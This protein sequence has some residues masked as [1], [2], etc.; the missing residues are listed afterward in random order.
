MNSGDPPLNGLPQARDWISQFTTHYPVQHSLGPA[1]A[2]LLRSTLKRI[3]AR[4]PPQ[5]RVHWTGWFVMLAAHLVD[6]HTQRAAT[7]D[8]D[9]QATLDRRIAGLVRRIDIES[10]AIIEIP[11]AK[12]GLGELVSH[13][14]KC[15]ITYAAY[16]DD[17]TAL[18]TT[19]AAQRAYS[20]RVEQLLPGGT[21]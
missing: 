15:W 9:E 18:S 11:T 17:Q 7:G 5:P 13:M 2:A 3:V 1:I 19:I 10:A 16:P 12:V 20:D 8:P 6:D 4:T 14:A 21:S